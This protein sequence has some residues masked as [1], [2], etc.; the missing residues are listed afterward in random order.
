MGLGWRV[1]R[2]IGDRQSLLLSNAQ[3]YTVG[4]ALTV[5]PTICT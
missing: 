3:W 4:Y 1:V 2:R 5:P